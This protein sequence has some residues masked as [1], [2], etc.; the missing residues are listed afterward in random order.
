MSKKYNLVIPLL[1][2]GSRMKEGGFFCPKSLIPVTNSKNILEMGLDSVETSECHLIFVTRKDEPEVAEFIRKKWPESTV[3]VSDKETKGSLHTVAL[4][5]KFINNETPLI[6]LNVDIH[7]SPQYIPCPEDFEDG[8]ILTF[9]SNSPN[10]SYVQCEN[11]LVTKTAEKEVISNEATVGLYCFKSGKLLIDMLSFA[12]M[13][14]NE[15][16]ICPFYNVLIEK[17]YKIKAQKVDKMYIFGTPS[18]LEFTRKYIVPHLRKKKI[19]LA[20]CHSGFETKERIKGLLDSYG[21]IYEDCGPDCAENCDYVDYTSKAAEFIRDGYFGIFMCESG[22]G[23]SISANKEKGVICGLV[24]N[25]SQ[26]ARCIEH[27]FANCISIPSNLKFTDGD[28]EVILMAIMSATPEGGRHIQRISRI[29][30]V[31]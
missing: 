15:Y 17:G 2:K 27:N 1:G 4:A 30:G 8:L 3:L 31:L 20:S 16:Y 11:G 7:F 29:P 9:K 21:I 25:Y 19:V 10:Y 13:T 24:T 14:K 26:V 18:E 12:P 22:Q 23:V 6:V 28:L 5:T